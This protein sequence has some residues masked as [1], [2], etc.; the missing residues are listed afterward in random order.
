MHDKCAQAVSQAANRKLTKAEL[1]GI[2]NRVRAGMRVVRNRDVDAWGAMTLGERINAGAEWAQQ[3]LQHEADLARQRK[4]LQLSKQVETDDRIDRAVFADPSKAFEKGARERAVKKDIEQTYVLVN[5]TKADYMRRT[6]GAIEGMKHGQSWLA[7]A[8]D[9][10][11]PAMER[12]IVREIYDP[13]STGNEVAKGA[14]EEITKTN[15]ALRVRFNSAGGNVGRVGYGYAPIKHSQIKVLGDGSDAQR[16][17]WAQFVFPL[18]DRSQ[19]LNDHGDQM[20]D[21]EVMRM[22]TGEERGPWQQARAAAPAGK[23]VEGRQP[24]IWD[25]IAGTVPSDLNASRNVVGARANANSQHRVLHFL[26]ADSHMAYNAAYGDG[27]MLDALY[28]HVNVMSKNVVLTERYG[29]NA[30]RTILGQIER[31][32]EHDGTPIRKLEKGPMSIGAY[33]DYVNGVTN[34]PV[35]PTLARQFATLRTAVTAFK[36]QGTVLAA[37]GDVGSMFV[38]AHYNKVPFFRTLGT[39]AKLLGP[40]SHDLRDWLSSQGIIAEELEHGMTRWGMDNLGQDWARNLA[41]S[42]MKFGGVSAWTD[43]MRTGF[44]ANMMRGLADMAPKQWAD[45]TEWDRRA[46]SRAGISESDWAVVNGA[47]LSE[48]GGNRYL[49]PDSIYAS[50]HPA[51][52]NVVPKI[53]GMIREEGEFAVLNPDLTAKVINAGSTGTWHGELQRT[54]MQFKTFPIAMVTRHWGRLAEM[55]RSGDYRVDGAPALAN[56]LA[57]GAALVVSTTI[58]GAVATQIKD[59]LAGKDPEPMWGDAGKAASFW[60]RAF[61]V[62]GGAGFIGDLVSNLFS[63]DQYGEFAANLVGGPVVSTA[64]QPLLAIKRNIGDYYSGKDTHFG[65]DLMKTVQSNLPLVNLWYWKTVWNRLIWD[66]IA[67][68][69]SPGVTQRNI[70]RSNQQYGNDYWWTPGAATPQRAPNLA[71]A[72]GG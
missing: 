36:L 67:E 10:D 39:A 64:I 42:T 14:A 17:R 41:A 30:T 24:G 33:W 26:D 44:Q 49:T 5:A 23:G 51:A 8:F 69:L 4:I 58:M 16:A 62:G 38:T 37:L 68:S 9:V 13:G 20:S 19:F 31:T 34:S 18:L 43:A 15:E 70:R 21:A 32:T 47:Q 40:G 35:D 61:S 45:L 29:P 7:R 60:G 12:D 52:A 50:G 63:S 22:L 53:L 3:Q 54:F 72:G 66:N 25:E 71:S 28:G 11:N 55:R 27:T 46:L 2:E 48:F 57:Y 65:A 59:L 56:P 1:D 6:M